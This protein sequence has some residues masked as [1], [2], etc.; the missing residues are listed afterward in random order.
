[1]KQVRKGGE[2]E[3]GRGR[4]VCFEGGERGIGSGKREPSQ[5]TTAPQQRTEQ[6][7]GLVS[8]TASGLRYGGQG[9]AART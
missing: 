4:E 6:Q 1:M 7:Q 2:E 3:E 9:T 5:P 8:A